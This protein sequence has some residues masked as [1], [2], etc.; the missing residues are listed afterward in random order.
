[1]ERGSDA[2]G[3]AGGA[4]PGTP[5][6]TPQVDAERPKS[7]QRD[8]GQVSK[9]G[10]GCLQGRFF[11]LAFNARSVLLPST[12]FC[13]CS[14]ARSSCFDAKEA[15]SS[16]TGRPLQSNSTPLSFL[17]GFRDNAVSIS[18]W[19]SFRLVSSGGSPIFHSPAMT[20]AMCG[21]PSLAAAPS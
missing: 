8:A 18:P 4:R 12:S 3:G 7:V 14:R 16:L 9:V 6:D 21:A 1:V 13:S 10:Q 20:L 5:L 17:R 11:T 2:A 15:G 19:S